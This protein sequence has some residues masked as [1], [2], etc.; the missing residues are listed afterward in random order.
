MVTFLFQ[1]SIALSC[2]SMAFLLYIIQCKFQR[3]AVYLFVTLQRVMHCPKQLEIPL[4][5]N[6]NAQRTISVLCGLNLWSISQEYPFF[7]NNFKKYASLTENC[8]LTRAL[9][10]YLRIN[11]L[12]LNFIYRQKQFTYAEKY[13]FM[14]LYLQVLDFSSDIF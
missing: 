8:T 4:K 14:C 10:V 9:Y 5:K 6:L 1:Q 2:L 12:E 11:N 13:I 7:Y 3:I